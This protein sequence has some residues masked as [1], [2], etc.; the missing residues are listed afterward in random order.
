MTIDELTVRLTV[1]VE[2]AMGAL[3]QLSQRLDDVV[4]RA[5]EAS[6]RMQI[7]G[8][9]SVDVSSALA[10]LNQLI[11]A[12]ASAQSILGRV[13]ASSLRQWDGEA[14]PSGDGVRS[15]ED[16]SR[17]EQ[18][19]QDYELIAHKRRMNEITLEDE[20]AMLE[21][22]RQ[23]HQLTA[24]EMMDWEERVHDVRQDIRRQEEDDLNRL[25]QSVQNALKEKYQTMRDTELN[26][27]DNSR[28]A[29]LDWR[30]DSLS[31]IDDQISALDRLDEAHKREEQDEKELRNIEKLRQDVAYEQDDYNRQMMERQLEEALAQREER[32]RAQETEDRRAALRQEAEDI[33]AQAQQRIDALE[34]EADAV[35]DAYAAL[36]DP[37]NLKTEA[38]Q[39][40]LSGDQQ[41]ILSLL[42]EF[43][44]HYD[45]LGR[46]MGEKLLD[47][48][49]AAVGDLSG[50]FDQLAMGMEAAQSQL[51]GAQEM[52][53]SRSSPN[54]QEAARSVS[55]QQT[56]HFHQQVESP[57]DVA[58]RM[59]AV[60]QALGVMMSQEG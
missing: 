33:R 29:W 31:A 41:Q 36:T 12:A 53:Y 30:D 21:A 19:R 50:W 39:L 43:T 15:A 17:Q 13:S 38:Q 47:G 42:S 6:S 58:R 18:I 48:F 59:E 44:P 55:V 20:L 5:L 32:L 11:R 60:N 49:R 51:A 14:S 3:G 34:R 4:R 28:Q 22:L 10:A 25:T 54:G 37:D 56:V 46:T 7:T 24:D 2:E 8:K 45:A 27:L 26:R 35:Q 9:A 52:A 1:E 40:V 23:K 16:S 57:G